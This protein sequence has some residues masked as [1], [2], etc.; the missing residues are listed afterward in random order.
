MANPAVEVQK[1]GQS[2][3][4][5]NIRRKLLNDGTFRKW[6]DEYGVLG[7]TSNPSIFQKAIGGSDDYDQTIRTLLN[8]Q[9]G[10]I[11]E[12]LAVAD[13]KAAAQ[14]FR[15]IYDR[16]NGVDG[17]VSLEVSPLLAHKTEET[18]EEAKRLYAAVN[19]PNVM[20]KI[21]ATPAGIPAIEETIAA[22]INVNVTLIFAVNNYLEVAEA[23]I[24]GLERRLEK[25]E[26]VSN[27]SSVASFFL[28][29]IDSMVD[30]ILENNI[31]AAQG[32]DLDRVASNSKLLGKAAISNAKLAYKRFMELFYGER[33]AKLHEAGAKVQRPLWASTSTKNPAYPDTLY[34][35]SLIGRDTVNTLP[36]DTLEAFKDHG[37]A[38]ESILDDIDQVQ[39]I[40]D[41]L[42]EVGVDMDQITQRLQDDG[43][44]AFATSFESLMEQVEGKRTV[45]L[46]EVMAH[47]KAALGIYSDAVDHALKSLDQKFINSRIWAK[48]GSVW[49][50]HRPTMQKIEQRLGWLD[51]TQ[52]IDIERLKKL[53]ADTPNMGFSHVVLLGM[54]GSSLAPEVLYETFGKR[55]RYPAFLMLDSTVPERVLEI[56][57]AVDLSKTLF[58]VASKSGSTIETE[59]F[60]NYFYE[61]TGRNGAQFIAITDPGSKLAETAQNEKFRDVFLNPADIGGR[62]SAL[63]YFGLVPAAL[64]GLDLDALWGSAKEMLMACGDN[65]P[66]NSHPGIYLGALIGT[67]AHQGRDKVTIFTSPSISTFGNW[68]EQL[69]AESTG[70]EGKGILPVV[71]STVGKPHDYA[72]DR[73]FVYLKVDGEAANAELDEK[74]R[75]LREA[76]HPRMTITLKDKYA[77]GG[78]FFRWMF[79][80]A[81]AGHI[82]G[83]NPFDEPNVTE[84]KQNT[85][86]LLEHYVKNGSLPQ[87]SPVLANG[88][89]QLFAAA[90]TLAPL[91]AV[92]SQHGFDSNNLVQLLAA[93]ILG[94]HAGDYF[95][96]LAYLPPSEVVDKN[97]AEVRRKLRHVTRRA[98]TVGY[99]PRYLH[100][101]GQLHKGGENNG[102]FLQ[103]T[104]DHTEDVA[105]P[106][107]PYSFGVLNQAQAAGDFEA[108]DTHKRRALRLHISG[109]LA[110]GLNV[111]LSAIQ[112]AEERSK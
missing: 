81:V 96:I 5:D 71:G 18:V 33:F 83:I 61:K 106:G 21:P 47:Q 28:S 77:L 48:D 55:E 10:D 93:Q 37:T 69:I 9:T 74:I 107:I 59:C 63:S 86:R 22:G 90:S 30:Q 46:T 98:V 67:L 2:I 89:V 50:D 45:L 12:N 52:T 65:I 91:R 20:I 34:V 29:R 4:I 38:R 94:T 27:I 70:K 105:I 84:S 102:V 36:P 97:L 88:N 62:Y 39:D 68:V 53:Q 58:I 100:S 17:Y 87:S 32:R 11:Y 1:Y 24:R 3:W 75:A 64:I 31:R 16:T 41:M 15:P 73:V 54:G 51:F 49:K 112:F 76:G 14:M 111:L 26:D 7:V 42:A 13:I 6:I 25:G 95:S 108:L 66:T 110:S 99:G 72:T 43:V 35:D 40:L 109:D 78:E 101:T 23:Y 8:Q 57:R 103:I 19:E 79:A 85:S 82:L 104:H 44:E 92:G 56:E 60:Y 80:T